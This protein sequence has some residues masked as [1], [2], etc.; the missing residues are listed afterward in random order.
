MLIKITKK[1]AQVLEKRL[2]YHRRMVW[3]ELSSEEGGK[4][5]ELSEEYKA[6]LNASKTERETIEVISQRLTRGGFL[7][8]D[9]PKAKGKVFQILKDKALI[10]AIPG[11]KPL[12]A[13]LQIIASHSDA[14]RLDLKQ[15]PLYEEADLAFLKTHYYGGI[16][17]YQWL[18]RPLAIHGTILTGQQKKIKLVIG[19]K[20]QDPV[21]SVADLLPHLARKIQM[22]KKLSE[23]IEGEKL[24]I[25]VGSI[26]L[27][28]EET[29]ER[30]K[31][32]VLRHLNE[33]YGMI[34]E[35]LISAELELVP[36]GLARDVGLDRGIIGAY[37]QDDR[38]C[39]FSSLLAALEVENPN[40]TAVILFFDKEEIGSEGN[41]S[42][43]AQ[44]L[45][46]FLPLL[47][48]LKG[49]AFS[50]QILNETLSAS[51]AISADVAG[52]LDP[53]Y[54]EVHEKRNAPRLGCG[55]C[56][57]KFTGSGGKIGSSDA[58]AEYVYW[59]RRLFNQNNIIWQTGELGKVDEGGGG[60]IAKFLATLG[61]DIVDCGTP[62]LS[63]HSPFE[64]V[65]KA[66]LYMTYKG[67]K[68]FLV[69]K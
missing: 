12:S 7:N 28:P 6:F 39:V 35:D 22:E 44:I 30:F 61:M 26:P 20:D 33:K 9:H 29:K 25:L 11:K 13:G 45:E 58:H 64:L 14:P 4:V 63:M 31:L 69:A 65:S 18:A 36:A 46:S 54:Q 40:K 37:G 34:E 57:T 59:I 47:F 1:E 62:V 48:S 38:A 66:D 24:N 43:R 42:A 32:A 5:Q 19:E 16:K 55:I 49:E 2:S 56:M 52:A 68:A 41:T 27:G 50:H 51:R 17:K 67:Y 15:H 10:L 3:D 8:L 53:D 60:T 21:F 23:A